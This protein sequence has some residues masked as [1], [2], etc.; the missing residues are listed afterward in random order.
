MSKVHTI[1]GCS[2]ALAALG[3]LYAA[4]Y[5]LH[6]HEPVQPVPFSHTTHAQTAGIPC[7]HCHTD[8]ERAAGVGLPSAGSCLDCH[9]HLL[10]EDPRLLPVQAAANRDHP[11]YTGEPLRWVRTAPLPAHV[12]FHHRAH[13]V[14]AGQDCAR[15]HPT[16]GESAGFTMDACLQCHREKKASTACTTCHH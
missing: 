7:L 8:A 12:R 6:R 15:C 1:W 16:P 9:L 4:A 3:V 10:A 5:R 2:V 11:A 13:T 14:L